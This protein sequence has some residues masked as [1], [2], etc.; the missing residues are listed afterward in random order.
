[1]LA[2]IAIAAT[3]AGRVVATLHSLLFSFSSRDLANSSSGF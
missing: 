1:M 2:V 3:Q